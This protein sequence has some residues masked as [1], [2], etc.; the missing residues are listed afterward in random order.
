MP[1]EDLTLEHDTPEPVANETYIEC[2]ETVFEA[3]RALIEQFHKHL[4]EARIRYIWNMSDSMEQGG[5]KVGATAE[6]LTGKL[7]LFA[8]ADFIVTIHNGT[9]EAMDEKARCALLDHELC[10]CGPKK[11]GV[12]SFKS[13]DLEE[14]RDVVLRHGL[15]DQSLVEVG[16]AIKTSEGG[17]SGAAG[18]S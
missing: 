11:D 3:C 8:D 4:V 13:H 18:T 17:Q 16:R 15:W 9:W 1:K 5:R 14:F 2:P 10:H 6:K 12:W 7:K